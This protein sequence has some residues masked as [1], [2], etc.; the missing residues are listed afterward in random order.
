M[1][2]QETNA[3]HTISPEMRDRLASDFTYHAPKADQPERYVALRDSAHDFARQICMMTPPSR[4]QS[5][6]ITHLE[7]A[8]F[9]ANA[10]IA[11][12]E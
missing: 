1:S 2:E 5:L 12:H 4:E 8:V 9:Y 7:E 3:V 6:A 10:A 11:R